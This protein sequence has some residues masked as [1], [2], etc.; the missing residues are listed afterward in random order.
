MLTC[1]LALMIFYTDPD[2]TPVTFDPGEPNIATFLG[3]ENINPDD[4]VA[5]CDSWGSGCKN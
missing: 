1:M 4:L 2:T 3:P 5:D